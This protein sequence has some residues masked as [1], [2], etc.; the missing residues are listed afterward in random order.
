MSEIDKIRELFASFEKTGSLE[1]LAEAIER[2]DDELENSE[3]V[4]DKEIAKNRFK[5]Y[6]NEQV[7]KAKRILEEEYDLDKMRKSRN[8]LDEFSKA[9]LANSPEDIV[10][11]EK[12]KDE[13]LKKEVLCRKATKN[14]PE[15][16]EEQVKHN[17]R[18]RTHD[19][20][21]IKKAKEHGIIVTEVEIDKYIEDQKE[22]DVPDS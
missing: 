14:T 20:L 18:S 19:K 17:L 9:G 22:K 12:V 11:L 4:R 8:V 3:N 13:L 1:T 7:A 15:Y 6:K 16:K 5:V 21:I 2:T 10:E